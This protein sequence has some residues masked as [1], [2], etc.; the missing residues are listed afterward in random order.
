MQGLPSH[1][2]STVPAAHDHHLRLLDMAAYVNHGP[3]SD[4]ALIVDQY[5]NSF[6]AAAA[7]YSPQFAV[8]LAGAGPRMNEHHPQAGF[9]NG[10]IKLEALEGGTGEQSAVTNVTS[11]SGEGSGYSSSGER[12]TANTRIDNGGPSGQSGAM[13]LTSNGLT[14]KV[15]AKR[16]L[17][18]MPDPDAEVVALSP[19]TLLATN[20][21][22]CEICNKGFQR[23]QNLQLHR[24]GHNLP[25]KLKQR[26]TKE[27]KKKVYVCPESSCVHHDPARALGDLTGIKKHFSR[28]HGEKKWKCD[29]CSKRYAVQSDWK[30]HSKTCGTREYRCDCGTL[31]SRRDSFITHRAFCDALAEESALRV[32]SQITGGH[33]GGD[34]HHLSS[35]LSSAVAAQLAQ[36][37]GA[38]AYGG[39]LGGSANSGLPSKGSSLLDH[40][41]PFDNPLM[42]AASSSSAGRANRLPLWLSAAAAA[43]DHHQL[44][45]V[46]PNPNN[47]P[48]HPS[49]LSSFQ[50]NASSVNSLFFNNSS[51][52]SQ[53]LLAQA[54]NNGIMFGNSISEF[55]LL[56]DPGT[57]ANF[58]SLSSLNGLASLSNAVNN[59]SLYGAQPHV[60]AGAPTSPQI[61]ATSL[62]QKAAQMGSVNTTNNP[63]LFKAG[64]ASSMAPVSS[65]D[66][67]YWPSTASMRS[68]HGLS[69]MDINHSL[70]RGQ[71]TPSISGFHGDKTNPVINTDARLRSSILNSM[72]SV[73]AIQEMVASFNN[74]GCS[75]TGMVGGQSTASLLMRG[76]DI[77]NG[78]NH[79]KGAAQI[80]T[81][82]LSHSM[83]SA[84][85]ASRSMIQPHQDLQHESVTL[86]PGLKRL[87]SK[88]IK[89][90]D[91]GAAADNFT[92]DFLGVRGDNCMLEGL[93]RSLSQRDLGIDYY[94]GSYNSSK[95]NL[96]S[97]GENMSGQSHAKP[98]DSSNHL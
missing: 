43:G 78:I 16:K 77:D 65:T 55:D 27:V 61:S 2:S 96:S 84:S 98:W 28:K 95:D 75:G 88:M 63:S 70:S 35:T 44:L 29:K 42:N 71:L 39:I 48:F 60:S 31:F 41:S 81:N 93:D 18:G 85:D 26:G 1:R 82:D 21:F 17:P 69:S 19:R 11:A 89:A 80:L 32:Q 4:T 45:S 73:S 52:P 12:E 54:G 87:P 68:S 10:M 86:S 5:S 91:V 37:S 64:L 47:I 33:L 24:R 67:L 36:V 38:S 46:S 57:N 49:F 40:M 72:D 92:R 25:W 15:K 53:S 7:L 50:T 22:V 90:E 59:S 9:M 30:A 8:G 58:A 97:E 94:N 34:H 76:S 74:G 62:L 79:T 3:N 66:A 56:G 51:L 13:G 23:D 20:R 6:N 83:L 14:I